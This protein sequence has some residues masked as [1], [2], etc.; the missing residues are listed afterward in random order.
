M[1]ILL[2]ALICFVFASLVV[3]RNLVFWIDHKYGF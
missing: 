2:A 3:K 1:N